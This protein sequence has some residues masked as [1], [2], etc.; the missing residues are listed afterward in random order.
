ML[1]TIL[2]SF[3]WVG[4]SENH[5]FQTKVINEVFSVLFIIEAMIKIIAFGKLYFKDPWNLL[6]FALVV[7]T[8]IMG[9]V[10]FAFEIEPNPVLQVL[11]CFRLFKLLRLFRNQQML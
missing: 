9:I 4:M 5:I 10:V 2:L 1:N 11:R 6:D 7:M 3:K 8:I